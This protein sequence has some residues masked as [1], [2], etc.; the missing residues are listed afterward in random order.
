MHYIM[1]K[2]I[3]L[4]LLLVATVVF[5]GC[6]FE[7]DDAFSES[8]AERL[9]EAAELY[10]E[11]LLAQ[12][13]GWAMQL[14]PT[15]DDE[16]PYGCG[17]LLLLRFSD[18]Y[19]VVAAMNN[20]LTDY[21]YTEDESAWEVI[22]DDGPV[23]TF[24]TYNDVI[25]FF[26]DP[27]D[28]AYTDDDD[29]TGEGM[30]GDYEWIIIE[31]PEDASYILLKGKKR[32]TYNLL[33]PIDEGVD[34]AEY[35]EDV[36]DFK[37]TMFPDDAPTYDL[38]YFGDSVYKMEDAGEGMPNI[39]PYDKDAVLYESLNAYV[40]SKNGDDYYFRFR[41]EITVGDITSQEF[42]YLPDEDIFQ[43]TENENVYMS[44]ADPFEFFD[45]EYEDGTIFT[46]SSSSSKMSSSFETIYDELT[47][48]FKSVGYTLG[49]ITITTYNNTRVLCV[50]YRSGSKTSY[51]YYT[52]TYTKNGDSV[53]FSFEPYNTA[54]QNVMNTISSLQTF[55]NALS[56]SFYVTA[57]TTGFDLSTLKLTAVDDEDFWFVLSV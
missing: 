2:N 27:D 34:Y 38:I 6:K 26:S 14:Y 48:G 19:S 15:T 13:N 55:I 51:S 57:A 25:H 45:D 31:A 23:L 1:T 22:T 49:T 30:G 20:E 7:E 39:Y 4:A 32:A 35:L 16:I 46:V 18:D 12:S 54:A 21:E 28:V 43:D 29:E 11:R 36:N 10:S 44:G 40:V 8:A 56:Q 47:S 50:A 3:S 33:T 5:S 42:V 24:N 17:Y 41:D 9:N 37:S 53:T 52:L